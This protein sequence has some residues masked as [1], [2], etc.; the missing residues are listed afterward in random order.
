MIKIKI[1]FFLILFA[2]GILNAQDKQPKTNPIKTHSISLKF[3]GAPT[4]P[5]GISYG[6]MITETP[7]ILH[8]L[9]KP[10][11]PTLKPK[12]VKEC[13]PAFTRQ[14]ITIFK[15]LN[16]VTIQFGV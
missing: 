14:K 1:A 13:N 10:H 7:P 11:K 3:N 15:F 8:T 9:P 12:L 4:W 16:F 2:P 6:Q 5:L